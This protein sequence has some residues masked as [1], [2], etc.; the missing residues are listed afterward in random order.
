[1]GHELEQ[2]VYYDLMWVVKAQSDC[3]VVRFEAAK[4]RYWLA[5]GPSSGGAKLSEGCGWLE[6]HQD[7]TL[8]IGSEAPD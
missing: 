8:T 4:C 7:V 1:M 3:S 6:P 5:D 2:Y